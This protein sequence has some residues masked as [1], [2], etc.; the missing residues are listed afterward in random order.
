MAWTKVVENK[1]E[2]IDFKVI[3]PKAYFY[4][5]DIML[6]FTQKRGSEDDKKIKGIQLVT[7]R[8]YENDKNLPTGASEGNETVETH[9]LVATISST[10]FRADGI[11]TD[12]LLF[13]EGSKIALPCPVYVKTVGGTEVDL[14]TDPFDKAS[15]GID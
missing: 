6:V 2:I 12:Q 9:A 10:Q 3:E 8:I 11:D 14:K 4:R 13:S 5:E 7:V 15:K 1:I